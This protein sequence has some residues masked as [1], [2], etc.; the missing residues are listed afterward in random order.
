M[1]D[2]RA[3]RRIGLLLAVATMLAGS[4]AGLAVSAQSNTAL[5]VVESR[6]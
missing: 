2:I 5:P 1:A 6:P 3:L 4:M